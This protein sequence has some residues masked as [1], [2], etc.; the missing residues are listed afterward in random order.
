MAELN[1]TWEFS[2]PSVKEHLI[3]DLK[4]LQHFIM[5]LSNFKFNSDNENFS[6][7]FLFHKSSFEPQA[8]C[9]MKVCWWVRGGL[10]SLVPFTHPGHALGYLIISSCSFLS[11]GLHSGSAHQLHAHTDSL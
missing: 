8:F 4:K 2:F 11:S 5:S 7:F 6:L 9:H 1:M 10:W 3:Y